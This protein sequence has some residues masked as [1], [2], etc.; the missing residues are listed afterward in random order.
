[1]ASDGELAVNNLLETMWMEAIVTWFKV[2]SRNS[3]GLTEE[4]QRIS[5]EYL[6]S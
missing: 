3:R 2:L 4:N 1:M 6:V 5:S